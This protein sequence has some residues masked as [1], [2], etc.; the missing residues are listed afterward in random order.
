MCARARAR[1]PVCRAFTAITENC[2]RSHNSR[3]LGVKGDL[4]ATGAAVISYNEADREN[5][6]STVYAPLRAS[7]K[8]LLASH[9][10]IFT[11]RPLSYTVFRQKEKL[12]AH[13]RARAAILAHG[14]SSIFR[15]K[16][17]SPRADWSKWIS[18]NIAK[19]QNSIRVTTYTC[20]RRGAVYRGNDRNMRPM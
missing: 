4:S 16:T 18:R 17:R 13:E 8:P 15:R 6:Q 3:F 9:T 5:F 7:R 20:E 12:Q 19:Y 1:D 2:P 10:V 11:R 14:L